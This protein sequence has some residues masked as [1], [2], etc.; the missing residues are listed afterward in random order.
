M[1][2]AD[3]VEVLPR[4]AFARELDARFRATSWATEVLEAAVEGFS[5]VVPATDWVSCVPEGAPPAVLT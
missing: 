4:P 2:T 5:M 3:Q 1:L